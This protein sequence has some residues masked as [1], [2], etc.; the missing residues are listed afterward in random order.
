MFRMGLP[1]S[2]FPRKSSKS[3]VSESIPLR[4][5]RA[6]CIPSV[7]N[8]FPDCPCVRRG[9][10]MRVLHV[11]HTSLPFICGYSIRSDYIFRCQREQGMEVAVVTSAQ[12]PNG[13]ILQEEIEG[14][15][16]WRTPSPQGKQFPILREAK[17]MRTLKQ[18]LETVAGTWKPDIIHAH[19]PMLV[20]LPALSV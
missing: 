11:L 9:F 8:K 6:V 5:K 19:S 10:N 18:R 4:S 13:E 17:L 12:H 2:V 16:F 20:G 1:S 15:P 3:T 7:S 14:I